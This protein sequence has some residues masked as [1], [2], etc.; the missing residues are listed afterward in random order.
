[1]TNKKIPLERIEKLANDVRTIKDFAENHN[2]DTSLLNADIGS[3]TSKKGFD[4]PLI[5]LVI[6]VL[7]VLCTVA[8]IKLWDPPLSTAADSFLF[9]LGIVFTIG[10][11]IAAHIRFQDK[12]VTGIVIIG[13]LSVL[14]IG[15]GI[16]SAREA[17]EKVGDFAK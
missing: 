17:V 11:S 10:A 14:L 2:F 13:L 8:I 16:F 3:P 1:M 9:L 4:L 7:L 12:V 5:C 15:A 6:G